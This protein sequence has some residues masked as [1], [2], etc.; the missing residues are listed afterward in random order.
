MRVRHF[1]VAQHD[2]AEQARPRLL[3]AATARAAPDRDGAA[4]VG[5]AD[6]FHADGLDVT[7]VDRLDRDTAPLV[8]VVQVG[9]L[10]V[11]AL[12]R[13]RVEVAI[14]DAHSADRA[15]RLGADLEPVRSGTRATVHDFDVLARPRRTEEAA[16]LDADRVVVALDVATG[17]ANAAARVGIDTV[18]Q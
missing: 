1:N 3:L 9:L 12:S 7:A 11:A 2:V 10:L 4:R 8:Q 5:D 14:G 18:R 6:P 15:A 13:P 17:D 16:R